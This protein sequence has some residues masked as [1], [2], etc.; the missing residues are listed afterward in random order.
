MKKSC[1]L[2][3]SV[4][5]V[6]GALATA[7]FGQNKAETKKTKHT[8]ITI[9][10]KGIVIK[11]SDSSSTKQP[12]K[13]KKFSS[14]ICMDLGFNFFKNDINGKSGSGSGGP[15]I[16]TYK[17][18][19]LDL[20]VGKSI[21]VNLYWL[22][23][24]RALKTPRERIYLSTGLGLQLYNFRYDK[25]ITYTRNPAGIFLDSVDF[26]KNKLAFDYLNVPLMV[27]MKTRIYQ[28]AADHKKDKWL[29]YGVG[30]TGGYALSIWTKQ[31]SSERGK[32]K[33]H[34]DFFFSRFNSCLTAEFGL[35][36]VIR[37]YG[38][39]QITDLGNNLDQHPICIGLK[40]SG[41]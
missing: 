38:T 24:F 26:K 20:N 21:N 8:E 35:D 27:T 34:D 5:L 14:S 23:T 19:L 37:F 9:S 15:T 39:Y 17:S 40:I 10:N 7:S 11:G 18:G 22:K 30:I 1:I 36:D 13:D 41:I 3:A 28:N 31:K 29:V 33:I 12:E 25:N 2:L 6:S 16:P 32:V 4:V